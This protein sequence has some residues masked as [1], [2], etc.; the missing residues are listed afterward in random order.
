MT[1]SMNTLTVFQKE[2][3]DGGVAVDVECT[4]D[5]TPFVLVPEAT[6]DDMVST[7]LASVV[8]FDQVAYLEQHGS[9][10]KRSL[11]LFAKHA[12]RFPLDSD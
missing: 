3:L 12:Y 5:V 9:G 4:V 6:V 10:L 1:L 11:D 2:I 7:D 8:T